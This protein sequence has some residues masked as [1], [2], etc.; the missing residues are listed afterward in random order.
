MSRLQTQFMS[1]WT[2]VGC[3]SLLRVD[4]HP[5]RLTN[6][7]SESDSPLTAPSGRV[8]CRA[9]RYQRQ[10]APGARPLFAMRLRAQLFARA[11][12][13]LGADQTLMRHERQTISGRRQ[14]SGDIA[15]CVAAIKALPPL[16]K[17]LLPVRLSRLHRGRRCFFC[18]RHGLAIVG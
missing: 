6:Q 14:L 15:R 11:C 16:V 3:R 1:T 8:Q 13:S 5:A 17:H 18:P 10:S 7:R 4:G 2:Y 9:L 12:R